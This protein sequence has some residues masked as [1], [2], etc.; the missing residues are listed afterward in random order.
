MIVGSLPW[1]HALLRAYGLLPEPRA[2]S[3]TAPWAPS[4]TCPC[5]KVRRAQ[6]RYRGLCGACWGN[7]PLRDLYAE[8]KRCYHARPSKQE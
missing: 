5:C 8:A 4:P 6:R 3:R 2:P 1:C 7:R